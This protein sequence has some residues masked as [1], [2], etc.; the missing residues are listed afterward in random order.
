MVVR[1]GDV[2]RPPQVALAPQAGLEGAT[3]QL[4]GLI[5]DAGTGGTLSHVWSYAPGADVDPGARCDLANGETVAPTI[6]CTDD[7]TYSLS[8]TV[9]NGSAS[10]SA[11]NTLTVGN[12]EPE[13]TIGSLVEGTIL[14]VSA[15]LSAD[16]LLS[17]PSDNDTHTCALDWGDGSSGYNR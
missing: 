4:H 9:S 3:I 17:D 11:F 6:R 5:T 8:F 14:P 16:V 10:A 13:V 1:D 12:L 15:P 7:G 2:L